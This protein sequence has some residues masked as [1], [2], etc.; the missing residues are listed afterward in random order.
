MDWFTS[1]VSVNTML[2]YGNWNQ[3][4]VF[5]SGVLDFLTL[6]KMKFESC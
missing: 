2:R 1:P 3:S 5:F 6:V 4:Y